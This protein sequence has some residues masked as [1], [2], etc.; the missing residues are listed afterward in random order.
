MTVRPTPEEYAPFYETYVKLVPE[1]DVVSALESQLDDSLFLL[2]S[3]SEDDSLLRHAPYT[4]STR[5]V[6]G[7]MTDAERVFGYRALRFA[8][9]DPTP[10][11]GFDE[12]AYAKAAH[13]DRR[14]LRDLAA[15][16]EAVRRANVHL[17]RA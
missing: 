14:E 12:G 6:V 5:E 11:P 16:F 4:W 9:A 13:F 3:I 17:F 10:L 7:H 8:R 1:V 15:E 2:H